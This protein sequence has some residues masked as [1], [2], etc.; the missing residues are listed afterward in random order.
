MSCRVGSSVPFEG[1]L[2]CC[3]AFV[4]MLNVADKILAVSLFVKFNYSIIKGSFVSLL[5]ITGVPSQTRDAD[6][7]LA[8]YVIHGIQRARAVLCCTFVTLRLYS[9]SV[10][11]YFVMTGEMKA[12]EKYRGIFEIQKS[13]DKFR[14]DWSRHKNTCKS[15][16]GKG[17]GIRRSKRPLLACCIRCICSMETLH[18]WVNSR[19]RY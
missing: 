16:S 10:L 2:R 19:I 1:R 13:G 12:K 11:P 18:N 17:P 15:Q 5:F 4:L 3:H 7:T 14:R 8:P 9:V 6:S